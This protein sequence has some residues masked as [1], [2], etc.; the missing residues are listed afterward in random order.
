MV[1]LTSGIHLLLP[2]RL[3]YLRRPRLTQGRQGGSR[4]ACRAFCT[5]RHRSLALSRRAPAQALTTLRR[6]H[7]LLPRVADPRPDVS[8]LHSRVA[9]F[10]SVRLVSS[11][12]SWSSLLLPR[13]LLPV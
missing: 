2:C 9:R 1:F 7:I 4:A 5:H 6:R 3:I 11:P 8:L 10:R 13:P 12:L